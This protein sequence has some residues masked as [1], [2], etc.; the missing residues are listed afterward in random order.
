[1]KTIKKL[2]KMKLFLLTSIIFLIGF[3]GCGESEEK[4]GREDYTNVSNQLDK[5]DSLSVEEKATTLASCA[6]ISVTP[7][8][9]VPE[10]L[11]T[12]HKETKDKCATTTTIT[13]S[14][15]VLGRTP[16]N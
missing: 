6:V 9:N 2:I 8:S 11:H 4:Q 5:W 15:S 7:E 13:A 16:A 10:S 12:L 14:E 3:T 1:M